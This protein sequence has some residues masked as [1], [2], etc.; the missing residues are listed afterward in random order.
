[1]WRWLL[2]SSCLLCCLVMVMI[3]GVHRNDLMMYFGYQVYSP[4]T[5][6]AT[7]KYYQDACSTSVVSK[8][9][10]SN[11]ITS[12]EESELASYSFEGNYAGI[13][14]FNP[15]ISLTNT[16][17]SFALPRTWSILDDDDCLNTSQ[18]DANVCIMKHKRSKVVN[19]V[20][21]SR[22]INQHDSVACLPSL[23]IAGFEKC[24][25]TQLLL[26]LSYHPNILGRWQETRF[27]S[28]ITTQA[29]YKM[30]V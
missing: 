3:L 20:A 9:E 10:Q 19:D 2:L 21:S 22:K 28:T 7:V 4:F 11:I 26:W 5:F 25:T 6:N 12:I 24:S 13:H 27:Y 29:N 23:V 14:S 8:I 18:L 1:M 15:S 30:N 16:H 17:N